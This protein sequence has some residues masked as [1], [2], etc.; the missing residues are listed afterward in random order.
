MLLLVGGLLALLLITVAATLL[1]QDRLS[2]ARN[3]LSDVLR[4]AQVAAAALDQTYVDQETTQLSFLL[5]GDSSQLGPYH[6]GLAS[7]A[8]LRKLL[9][10]QLVDDP[11]SVQLLNQV[12]TDSATW[13]GEAVEPEIAAR[14]QGTLTVAS[15]QD[16]AAYDAQLFDMLRDDLGALQNRAN[17][18][19]AAEL[20]Q[21]NSAQT[22]VY[23]LAIGAGAFAVVL[24]AVAFLVLRRSLVRP[25]N[26]LIAQVRRVRAGD[27]DR[28]VDA[29][30]PAEIA[31]VAD[32]VDD[33]RVRI[34][35]ETARSAAGQQRV[36]RYEEA[37][38]I[39]RDLN[40]T[41]VQRLF[42]TGLDL[43]SVASRQPTVAPVLASAVDSID[44]AIQE[45]Q[46]GIFGL[47][48]PP[49]QDGLSKRVLD[50]V[51]ESE[52]ALGLAPRVDFDGTVDRSVPPLVD[53]EVVSALRRIL[54]GL[55]GRG[56]AEAVR[57]GLR[58]ADERLQLRVTGTAAAGQRV[59]PFGSLTELTDR[60]T[61]LGGSC[62]LL[63]ED[64]DG[65]QTV[66]WV[67]PTA[68]LSRWQ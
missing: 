55:A 62:T 64:S 46:V 20:Q 16:R 57:I 29:S 38:R 34:L 30:G 47:A 12:D 59:E 48:V 23:R 31:E 66:E 45:L 25:L 3:Q 33:M 54:A 63:P 5:T 6:S 67:V 60:A 19:V 2:Q 10:E 42:R 27:L 56:G 61:L 1:V 32:A 26:G 11:A 36:A 65:S 35:T 43:Q 9:G 51:S 24:S 22:A 40:D 53:D 37:E 68:A 18:L 15:L 7:T 58:L 4:P 17:E 28:S 49:D 41:V 14:Q 13:R 50:V 8:R 21:A 39:A 52:T 44:R